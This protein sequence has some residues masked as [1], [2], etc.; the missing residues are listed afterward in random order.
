V[1][2]HRIDLAK[3]A[4]G[5]HEC[6]TGQEDESGRSRGRVSV[7]VVAKLMLDIG[8]IGIRVDDVSSPQQMVIGSETVSHHYMNGTVTFTNEGRLSVGAID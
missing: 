7:A 8:L 3:E 2:E 4:V 6:A 5:A 1:G